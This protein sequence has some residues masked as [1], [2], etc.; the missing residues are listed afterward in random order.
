VLNPDAGVSILANTAAALRNLA[1]SDD[2]R[3]MLVEEGAVEALVQICAHEHQAVKGYAVGALVNLSLRQCKANAT[4]M[5]RKGTVEPL[6]Q[7]CKS[8]AAGPMVKVGMRADVLLV[9]W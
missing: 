6:I 9:L 8:D 2:M 1:R 7:L 4:A 3:P 5:V